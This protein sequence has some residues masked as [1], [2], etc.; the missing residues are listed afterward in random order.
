MGRKGRLEL[1][2]TRL[3]GP[4]QSCAVH[5]S[6]LDHELPDTMSTLGTTNYDFDRMLRRE[7]L[8]DRPVYHSNEIVNPSSR[9]HDGTITADTHT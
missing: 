3:P 1:M 7:Q 8:Q 5:D 2:N 9:T 4:R 6:S